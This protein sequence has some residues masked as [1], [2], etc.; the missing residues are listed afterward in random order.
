M[1][2]RLKYIFTGASNGPF[3]EI[4]VQEV[5]IGAWE[6]RNCHEK[7]EFFYW[8]VTTIFHVNVTF[9]LEAEIKIDE[10][11]FFFLQVSSGRY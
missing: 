4:F 6:I 11:E 8:N 7:L 10:P 5:L 3:G 2:K 1:I 9:E